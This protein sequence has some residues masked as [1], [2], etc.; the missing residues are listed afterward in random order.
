M[1][2]MF[3]KKQSPLPK[4]LLP[5]KKELKAIGKTSDPDSQLSIEDSRILQEVK[6]KTLELNQN[7]V[8]RTKAYLDF[9]NACPEI[10]WA[11][12]A[13]MV[14]R[15]GGWN[16]TDLKGELLTRL[17]SQKEQKSFFLFLERANW[18]IFQDAYPQLLIYQAGLQR[19]KNLSRLLPHLNISSFMKVLWNHFWQT[20]DSALLTH[21]LI[22]NEQNYVETRVVNHPEF[23]KNVLGSLEFKLQ[24]Y[25][26]MN[27]ILFPYLKNNATKLSGQT[28][29][30]FESLLERIGIGK[31][32][33]TLL[34]SDEDRLHGTIRWANKYP[35]TGSRKD[36]WPH[37]FNFIHEG[38]PGVLLLP[39]LVSCHLLPG[40]SKFYSPKLEFA[41]KEQEHKEAESGDW[42]KNWKI[43]Y[44]LASSAEETTGDIKKDYCQTLQK[45]ELA[46]IAKKTLNSL[47]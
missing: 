44:H 19:K 22:V 42:Y 8:T 24:D 17:M 20:R 9:Y 23:Q 40:F 26:S 37:L 47:K 21:A 7:N 46:A 43:I 35:H 18:L 30:Q 34:F 16:M 3:K 39:R 29:H 12:L 2:K 10:H 32:L 25:L 38:K 1:I 31:R 5:I 15:N 13:H 28:V 36:Y 33:Y 4:S 6:E 11:L 45:L 41:W 14:S 27:H